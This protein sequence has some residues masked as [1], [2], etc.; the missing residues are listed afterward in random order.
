MSEESGISYA[1]MKIVRKSLKKSAF[2]FYITT[3]EIRS[4]D[5]TFHIKKVKAI[6]KRTPLIAKI[7]ALMWTTKSTRIL[8]T[9]KIHI[10]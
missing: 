9:I 1:I 3:K 10:E 7:R 4:E 8:I 2:I 5:K 6:I